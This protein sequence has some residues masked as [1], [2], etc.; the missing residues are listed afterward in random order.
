MRETLTEASIK[1]RK[2]DPLKRIEISDALLPALRLV[3]APTGVKSWAVRYK[4]DG[5]SKKLTLGRAMVGNDIAITLKDA[6]TK[7]RAALA[8]LQHGIDPAAQKQADRSARIAAA[9]A[10]KVVQESLVENALEDFI[11]RHVRTKKSGYE[12]ERLLRVEVVPVWRGL[13]VTEISRRDVIKLLDAIHDRG[14]PTTARRVL[15]NLSKCFNWLISRGFEGLDTN[16]CSGVKKPSPEVQRERALTNEELRVVLKA[17]PK[18]GYPWAGWIFLLAST[19]VRRSEASGAR[20]SELFLDDESPEWRLPKERTKN[21]RPHVVPLT[22]PVVTMLRSVP[23]IA[24]SDFVFTTTGRTPVSG[25]GKAKERLDK[26]IEKV[27]REEAEAR[28]ETDVPPALEHWQFHDFRR[29]CSTG[30]AGLG[31]APH[32]VEAALNHV[33]G[34]KAGV[35]GVYNRYQYG[36][37][38]KIAFDFWSQHIKAAI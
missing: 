32:I 21:G 38:K 5:V 27:L 19:G 11:V 25:F 14:A 23:K 20:W 3:V 1:S 24:G 9:R 36:A 26:L 33:S 34:A 10:E 12:V 37:E 4:K 2:A 17:A 15:A 28:G 22:L 16:P 6:R 35:A 31:I 18:M 7:A 13:R 30:M 8:Q 29:T